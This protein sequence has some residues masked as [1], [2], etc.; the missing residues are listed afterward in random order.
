MSSSNDYLSAASYA[1]NA[2]FKLSSQGTLQGGIA[3]GQTVHGDFYHNCDVDRDTHVY[4]FAVADSR[5][6]ITF[7]T[8]SNSLLILSIVSAEGDVLSSCSSCTS[9]AIAGA[10]LAIRRSHL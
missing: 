10:I 7:D 9:I 8:T 2:G 5:A 1:C 6:E 3:C 4:H